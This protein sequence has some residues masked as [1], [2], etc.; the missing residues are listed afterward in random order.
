[1]H[2]FCK[3]INR[4]PCPPTPN[5]FFLCQSLHLPQ[6]YESHLTNF[7]HQNRQETSSAT[8]PTFKPNDFRAFFE[9]PVYRRRVTKQ[10]AI[11]TKYE[12]GPDGKIARIVNGEIVERINATDY[13]R[14]KFPNNPQ[15]L[16]VAVYDINNQQT[17][18]FN[19]VYMIGLR[20]MLGHY[21]ILGIKNSTAKGFLSLFELITR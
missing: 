17:A 18:E 14:M 6:I 13:S 19:F 3:S 21:Q 7:E 12:Y 16:N 2:N 4:P 20:H 10:N 11:V 1:M 9:I 15:A 8:L 5:S